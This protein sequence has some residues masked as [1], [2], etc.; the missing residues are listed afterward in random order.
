MVLYN[1]FSQEASKLPQVM[2]IK[3]QSDL[4]KKQ[5]FFELFTLTSGNS[6]ASLGKTSYSTSYERSL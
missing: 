1:A 6:D 3:L 4:K 2:N 5:N